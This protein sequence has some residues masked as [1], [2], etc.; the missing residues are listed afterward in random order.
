MTIYGPFLI[1]FALVLIA[2]QLALY[3]RR[4]RERDDIVR[5]LDGLEEEVERAI[6][7]GDIAKT[8]ELLDAVEN[9]EAN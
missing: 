4:Q 1:A 5:V 9:L 3:A 7:R 2:I 8:R 6:F